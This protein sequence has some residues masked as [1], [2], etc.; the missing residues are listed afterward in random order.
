MTTYLTRY[1]LAM[2]KLGLSG[3]QW[4]IIW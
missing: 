2:I 3:H 1:D 4:K